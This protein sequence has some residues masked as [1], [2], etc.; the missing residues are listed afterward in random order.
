MKLNISDP[1]SLLPFQ[2]GLVDSPLEEKAAQG[3]TSLDVRQRSLIVGQ[4]VPIVF[5]RRL[6][7][8]GGVLVAPGAS[9]GRFENN[10]TSNQLTV[11]L[12]LV[13]SEGQ[14]DA[15]K[16]KDV[17]QRA[18]RV[19]TWNQSYDR[20]A[21][22]WVPGTNMTTVANKTAWRTPSYCG[23][24]GRYENMTTLS[25]T[26]T[27]EDA[28]TTWDR[29]VYVMCRD[30]MKVTRILDD[31]LGPSNNFID[32]AIYLIKESKRLSDSLIDNT[33]MLAAATFTNANGLLFNGVFDE[34]TNLEDWLTTVGNNFLLRLTTI[35]GKIAFKPRLPTNAN[36]TIKT[37]AITPVFT[38]AEDH[39]IP[40][41][42]QISYIPISERKNAAIHVLY[43]QQP[44]DD[45]GLIRTAEIKVDGEA[46]TGPFEQH[47]MSKYCASEL[48]AVRVG[49]FKVARRKSI[50]HNLRVSVRPSVF[51]A[52]LVLGDIVRVRL[53]RESNTGAV[54]SHDY[55]YEVERIDRNVSGLIN[56]DLTHFPIDNQKRSIVALLT[57]AATAP[58]STIPTG[59]TDFT[60]DTGSRRT[61]DTTAL[62]DL[63]MDYSAVLASSDFSVPTSANV[64]S[65]LTPATTLE[66]ATSDISSTLDG[67][68]FETTSIDIGSYGGGSYA[69][70]VGAGGG[71]GGGSGSYSIDGDA[72]LGPIDNASD[73]LDAPTSTSFT[74]NRSTDRPLRVGDTV[75]SQGPACTNGRILYYRGKYQL[76]GSPL[77][78]PAA[79]KFEPVWET[80]PFKIDNSATVGSTGVSSW[81]ISTSDDIIGHGVKTV[82]ECPDESSPTGFGT[83]ELIGETDPEEALEPNPA[84]YKYARWV[85]TKSSSLNGAATT[86][87]EITT[88]WMQ[89]NTYDG[90]GT[91]STEGWLRV[92]AAARYVS[93][94]FYA[95]IGDSE[96]DADNYSYP[97][98]REWNSTVKLTTR[99]A[100]SMMQANIELGGISTSPGAMSGSNQPKIS[101]IGSANAG[102]FWEISGK[103]E[104]SNT[105][106]GEKVVAQ[107]WDGRTATQSEL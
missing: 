93:G 22:S 85:G 1:L 56:L 46:A 74:D 78:D 64:T 29:Q 37:T 13:L 107:T 6:N 32:L 77:A 84:N 71:T 20:R 35:N 70:Y 15:I 75:T 58:G 62:T 18:C 34:S 51:N 54:S 23:T 38:F 87:E 92:N 91:L 25:Y 16:L 61:D 55:M 97:T 52:T 3:N 26:N 95:W 98:N 28:D 96:G 83:P 9:E 36:G 104:F 10:S 39:I 67:Q 89:Y 48:G 53:R 14:F 45:L 65:T 49:A 21:E 105:D 66:T 100:V 2:S 17:F 63:G 4:P 41:S 8:E 68:S 99:Q 94:S 90:S 43:R 81:V 76:L 50:T 33:A 101:H 60:C 42:F 57:N 27:H 88:N 19:G 31:T 7:N 73:P 59:R 30:G 24:S 80:T 103:W 72:S 106:S 102:S 40:G 86:T 82:R 5:C 79:R 12:M 69:N 47:D 44:D 11:K